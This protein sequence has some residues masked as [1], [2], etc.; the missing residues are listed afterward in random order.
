MRCEVLRPFQ[1]TNAVALETGQ[2]VETNGWRDDS[3]LRLIAQR[4]LRQVFDPTPQPDI[5]QIAQTAPA[6]AMD[7]QGRFPRPRRRA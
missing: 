3:V 5:A 2:I 1:A 7:A 4:Y 6:L